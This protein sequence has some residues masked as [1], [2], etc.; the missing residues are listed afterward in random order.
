M[1]VLEKYNCAVLHMCQKNTQK[2]NT[3]WVYSMPTD[4]K[5]AANKLM[6]PLQIYHVVAKNAICNIAVFATCCHQW[7]KADGMAS[8]DWK[9]VNTVPYSLYFSLLQVYRI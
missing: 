2:A 3:F 4:Y 7:P 6:L 5:K 8:T 1:E 9:N